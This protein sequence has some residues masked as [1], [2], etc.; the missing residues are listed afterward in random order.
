MKTY[1]QEKVK[2]WFWP[3]IFA[4]LIFVKTFAYYKFTTGTVSLFPL[5]GLTLIL[6]YFC[7]LSNKKPSKL[8]IGLDLLFSI[9]MLI[10]SMHFVHFGRYVSFYDANKLAYAGP[11]LDAIWDL[12]QIKYILYFVNLLL[13]LALKIK[14]KNTFEISPF[15]ADMRG[16][17]IGISCII[18]LGLQW[19]QLPKSRAELLHYHLYDFKTSFFQE[20]TGNIDFDDIKSIQNSNGG[21]YL[22]GALKGKN[23][24]NIQVESL[25]TFVVGLVYNGQEVTPNLNGLIRDHSIYFKNYYQMMDKGHTSDAEFVINNSLYPA[26]D[27][28]MYTTYQSNHYRGL[29]I[30]LGDNGYGTYVFHGY[31]KEFWNRG[32]AYPNQGFKKFFNDEDYKV[33]EKIGFGLTDKDFFKQNIEYLKQLEQPYYAF[34]I[35]LTSHVPFELPIEYQDI[36]LLAQHE[37]TQLGKYLQAIHYTDQALGEFIKELKEA[38]LYEDAV[39]SIY[40]DHYAI[41]GTDKKNYELMTEFLGRPYDMFEMNQVPMI[42][43]SQGLEAQ[44]NQNVGSHL[45]YMPTMLNLLGITDDRAVMFGQDLLNTDMGYVALQGLYTR[46]SFVSNKIKY[47]ASRNYDFYSGEAFDFKTGEAI[48]VEL[49]KAG[50]DKALKDARTSDILLKNDLVNKVKSE[51]PTEVVR[52]YPQKI[53]NDFAEGDSALVPFVWDDKKLF[54]VIKGEERPFQEFNEWMNAQKSRETII[55][56][57]SGLG[58]MLDIVSNTG[59]GLKQR[60]IPMVYNT[61]QY[62]HVSQLGF[63]RI[64]MNI[65][66]QAW[67]ENLLQFIKDNKVGAVL[68]STDKELWI[69]GLKDTPIVIYNPHIQFSI[70]GIKEKETIEQ[71]PIQKEPM[72]NENTVENN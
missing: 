1:I 28:P 22:K 35:T 40:G 27:G 72:Q 41:D 62:E 8:G 70:D 3:I 18:V 7:T 19:L 20:E 66:N 46:G 44:I 11:V 49:A 34:M 47:K 67:D 71:E 26:L 37:N 68:I 61:K 63:K 58:Q 69:E 60:Y 65:E 42:I 50:F 2:I 6:F 24:I 56:M 39:I 54:A 14:K 30:V 15:R 38:G 16:I 29:P 48:D 52:N 43:H 64:I 36:R 32:S 13:L 45:D 57:E 59:D 33:T 23:L 25:S 53:V 21:S 12:V 17:Y 10:N 31:D 55:K 51:E 5:T 9:M 4:G